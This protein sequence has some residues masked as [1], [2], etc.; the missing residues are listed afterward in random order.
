MPILVKLCVCGLLNVGSIIAD[1]FPAAAQRMDD[2]FD[3][4]TKI[5]VCRMTRRKIDDDPMN[6]KS[7]CFKQGM[8][9]RSFI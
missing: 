7:R 3:K 4:Q 9:A 5:K 2:E 8:R 6:S 1:L